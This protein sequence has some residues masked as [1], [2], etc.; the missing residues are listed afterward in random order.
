MAALA[1]GES[2][3]EN[4]EKI[5]SWEQMYSSVFTPTVEDALA[6]LFP[7]DDPLDRADFDVVDYLNNLFPNEQSLVSVESI[8]KK[9]TT[10][11]RQ[12]EEG[13][14][15]IVRSENG[16][17]IDGRKCLEDANQSVRELTGKLD[18]IKRR[19]EESESLVQDI[20]RDI[21]E[22]DNAKKNLTISVDVLQ[23]LQIIIDC[24]DDLEELANDHRYHEA[25]NKI[26][27]VQQI[28]QEF[29]QYKDI[30]KIAELI[31]DSK[32][33][34][35]R[36]K[37]A[38]NED[39]S[40]GF[41]DNGPPISWQLLK[42]ACESAEALGPDFKSELISWVVAKRLSDHSHLFDLSTEDASLAMVDR[43]YA[44][45]KRKLTSFDEDC[46]KI[47][48]QEWDMPKHMS[49]H[50]CH[51]TRL[52]L[53]KLL[54][55]KKD[56]IDLKTFRVALAKTLKFERFLAMRFVAL[57]PQ[58]SNLSR[59]TVDG[60]GRDSDRFSIEGTARVSQEGADSSSEFANII[61][62]VFAKHIDIYYAAQNKNIGE[63]I[64][65]FVKTMKTEGFT[66]FKV[67]PCCGDLFSFFRICL[68]ELK[69]L[70][71]IKCISEVGKIFHEN[72]NL[73][74]HKVL[75]GSLPKSSP[76]AMGSAVSNILK[77]IKI[78]D[79]SGAMMSETEVKQTCVILNSGEY[80]LDVAKQLEKKLNEK[81]TTQDAIARGKGS[82][83]E[84][85]KSEGG[86]S[87]RDEPSSSSIKKVDMGDAKNLFTE[88][89]YSSIA[90]L[91]KGLENMLEGDL[92]SLSKN[93][94]DAK[95]GME[96]STY[97]ENVEGCLNKMIPIIR[98]S[99]ATPKHFNAMCLK[100]VNGFIPALMN[101]IYRCRNVTVTG[102]ERLLLDVQS[103]KTLLLE[104]PSLQASTSVSVPASYQKIVVT[105][106]GQV[107]SLL[108][109]LMTPCEPPQPFVDSYVDLLK[110]D[111]KDMVEF[112]KILDIRGLKRHEQQALTDA[113]KV[114]LPQA[115]GT[116][117]N[118]S[119]V[120]SDAMRNVSSALAG[121]TTSATGAANKASGASESSAPATGDSSTSS[122]ISA[123]PYMMKLSQFL[124]TGRH[125]S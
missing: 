6:R 119:T 53:Q 12:I 116:T 61:T 110:D 59:L 20:T 3:E 36:L 57:N 32:A 62:S 19:A 69:P 88:T 47:F 83:A 112:V 11:I 51:L 70:N 28:A 7:S 64:D 16:T 97:L 105:Q 15:S 68:N 63:M 80:C 85:D 54:K 120:A 49:L 55:A 100:F 41:P 93:R 79:G 66:D 29:E 90:V 106:M 17:Q 22:L 65:G 118:A 31:E 124:R 73:F 58:H 96:K 42:A 81:L 38:I 25:A 94:W 123:S 95:S 8:A 2:S 50:F 13:I 74:A 114:T 39:F 102:A 121:G 84:S 101:A 18:E 30:P 122:K 27:S 107:E 115:A 98:G 71:D 5:E 60:P 23:K 103:L 45:L 108:M 52:D 21:K 4:D 92:Q 76:G 91:A 78:T 48:P 77:D 104:L 67:L 111:K 72:L 89:I 37:E 113:F 82:A 44:Y 34:Q 14:R 117:S 56:N 125:K 46:R 33:M 24:L 109:V 40:S 43:R 1:P 87:K 35:K 9:Y 86:T 10:Q 75:I 99:V 26:Q